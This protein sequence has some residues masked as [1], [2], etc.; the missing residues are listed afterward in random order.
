LNF[1]LK[2]K[3]W[4]S[5]KFHQRENKCIYVG[6]FCAGEI[7]R[8]NNGKTDA[9]NG[10]CISPEIRDSGGPLVCEINGEPALTGVT[11]SVGCRPGNPG[12]YVDIFHY[13]NW[14]K[15]KVRPKPTCALVKIP[16]VPD[17]VEHSIN[18]FYNKPKF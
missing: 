17:R 15:E 3:I 1:G 10:G 7:D 18:Y 16:A 6:K 2:S 4:V 5:P 14:I 13:S 11:I 12:I 8:D 9:V